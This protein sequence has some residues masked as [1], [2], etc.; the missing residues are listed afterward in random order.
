MLEHALQMILLTGEVVGLVAQA[1]MLREQVGGFGKMLCGTY[2]KSGSL[3]VKPFFFH[4]EAIELQLL[5]AL[6]LPS[7]LRARVLLM[8]LRSLVFR[9]GIGIRTRFKGREPARK[10]RR[11]SQGDTS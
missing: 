11:S 7:L 5:V 6:D 1:L 10:T 9:L 3:L 2:V 8:V 4:A